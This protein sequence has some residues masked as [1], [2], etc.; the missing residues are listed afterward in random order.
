MCT[1]AC[2]FSLHAG[3]SA[4]PSP[5]PSAPHLDKSPPLPLRRGPRPSSR[6]PT[7][8]TL[9]HTPS[10]AWRGQQP[11][12][13]FPAPPPRPRPCGVGRPNCHVGAVSP[14]SDRGARD[15]NTGGAGTRPSPPP[16]PP[17][18][19]PM[20]AGERGG[21]G[22]SGGSS[23]GGGDGGR[24]AAHPLPPPPFTLR[25]PRP[26]AAI[27]STHVREVEAR[28]PPDLRPAREATGS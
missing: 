3:H 19:Q 2:P 14:A 18:P 21:S 12:R 17:S 11:P 22:G 4:P 9:R 1:T 28:P 23:G 26:P 27:R 6:R 24:P 10:P 7:G 20:K 15:A 8:A 13:P 25:F 16:H 5:L